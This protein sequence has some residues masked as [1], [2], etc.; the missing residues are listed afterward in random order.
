MM[1]ID[2]VDIIGDTVHVG[3]QICPHV[4]WHTVYKRCNNVAT[5]QA[6]VKALDVVGLPRK[7]INVRTG[8]GKTPPKADLVSH[9]RVTGHQAGGGPWCCAGRHAVTIRPLR[10]KTL[11]GM[12]SI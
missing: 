1:M 8:R 6:A 10:F 9:E 2:P 5:I 7:E 12:G 4:L 3:I 11:Q